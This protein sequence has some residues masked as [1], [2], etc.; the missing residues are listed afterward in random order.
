[1]HNRNDDKVHTVQEQ[2]SPNTIILTKTT[3]VQNDDSLTYHRMR[4]LY[5]LAIVFV[6]SIA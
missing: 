2:F 6:R 5:F 4:G 1:M 3:T